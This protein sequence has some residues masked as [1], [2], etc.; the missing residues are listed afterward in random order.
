M[1]DDVAPAL[2]VD[3]LLRRQHGH[4]LPPQLPFAIF[5]AN[6]FASDPSTLYSTHYSSTKF[7]LL[8]KCTCHDDRLLDLLLALLLD[9]SIE[10][11][12]HIIDYMID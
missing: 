5:D 2:L 4:P 10:T 3:A 7:L 8:L 9:R 1:A 6:V 12:L 11:N